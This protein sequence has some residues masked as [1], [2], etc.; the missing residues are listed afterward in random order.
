MTP[1]LRVMLLIDADNVSADVI[2]QA[3]QRTMDE[4][5]AVHVRRAYC[6]AEMAVNRQG[7]SSSSRCGRWSI[8]RPARTAPTSRSRSMRSTS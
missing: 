6:N 3:V 4:Y 1:T 5:G 8:S 7:C 2:E